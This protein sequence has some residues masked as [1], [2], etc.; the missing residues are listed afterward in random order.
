MIFIFLFL[1]ISR[2][3]YEANLTKPPCKEGAGLNSPAII[4]MVKEASNS[5][6]LYLLY[7]DVHVS[8]FYAGNNYA[9]LLLLT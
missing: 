4:C 3:N 8:R 1:L 6:F 9:A 5:Y 2:Q 7:Q